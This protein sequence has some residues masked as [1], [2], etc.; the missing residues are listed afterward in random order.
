MGITRDLADY[1]CSV[2]YSDFSREV[3]D[4]SKEAFLDWIGV[5]IAG[6]GEEVG[7]KIVN[8][9]KSQNR[10][11]EASII[12]TSVKATV[13]DAA[14]AMGTL[15]HALDFDD[16]YWPMLGHPSAPI[17]PVIFAF[18]EAHKISG[19][20]AIEAFVT[21]F[22]VEAILGEAT[23]EYHY[24]KGWH[25]TSTIGPFGATAAGAKILGLDQ[26]QICDA[27]GMAA[28]HA[29]GLR[30][31]FGTMTKP[32]HA[33]NAARAG[34]VSSL[35]ARGGFTSDNDILEA[36]LGFANVFCGKGNHG[37]GRIHL[38]KKSMNAWALVSPGRAVKRYPSCAATHTA[39][40]CVLEIV[41]EHKIS[42]LEI[43]KVDCLVNP[44][45]KKIL[46]KG[47]PKTGLEGKF[48][49][50]YC[51]SAA[52]LDGDVGLKQFT[53]ENVMRNDVQRLL[54][55]INLIDHD[56]DKLYEVVVILKTKTKIIEK[57]ASFAKGSPEN[58][59]SHDELENK[60]KMCVEK[61]LDDGKPESIMDMVRNLDDVKNMDMIIELCCRR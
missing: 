24:H 57:R 16:V 12:G 45:L 15:S 10:N 23:S 9:A 28:S 5:T 31:N 25:T 56:I 20:K 6:T 54:S 8:Y 29:S 17:F 37:L 4:K 30:Q 61:Y 27:M 39:I 51:L 42:P 44:K 32:L 36:E 13:S 60:F 26:K 52:M 41:R 53:D 14:L 3:I 19:E 22:E 49:M 59:M 2:K 18:G 43:E 48:S 47:A 33:G 34:I 1:I 50:Q 38:D 46:V 55:K 40:D 58:P 21:G 35:L 7:E 11:G